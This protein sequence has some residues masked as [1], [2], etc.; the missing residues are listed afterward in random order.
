MLLTILFFADYTMGRLSDSV[1]STVARQLEGLTVI[2]KLQAEAVSIRL[3]EVQLSKF[4]DV[5]A[6]S[7][8]VDELSQAVDEFDGLLEDFAANCIDLGDK[9]LRRLYKSWQM[10]SKEVKKTTRLANESYLAE[11]EKHSMFASW[12]R[13][14]DFSNRLQQRSV[15]IEKN[16]SNKLRA[17]NE[18][19][20]SMRIKFLILSGLATLVSLLFAWFLSRSMSRRIQILH[21][22][23]L[24][25]ADGQLTNPVPTMGKDEIADLASAFNVMRLKILKREKE[26]MEA[27]SQLERR[28]RQRTMDLQ[29]ANQ[30]LEQANR[31]A[32][33]MTAE[34][35]SASKAK[36]AFLANM[37]HEI[38]TPMN[39]V[40]GMTALLLDTPLNDEQRDFA[41]A[42][43]ASGESLLNIINDILDFSKIE[44]GKL[45][46]ESI[47]FDL[48]TIFDDMADML[49]LDA[50]KKG[51]ELC[52]FIDP[53][54]P[55][56]LEGDPVRMRQVLLNL[57]N[58]AIKFTSSG[59]V[60]ILAD[61][62]TDT[63]DRVEILFQIN[64]TGIGIPENRI[65]C[66]FKSFSQA[67]GST[68][69]KYG[70][71]GLGLAI[72][73]RLV[74]LMDGQIGV[75]NKPGSGCTFWFTAWLCKQLDAEPAKLPL[76]DLHAKRILT[77][78]AHTTRRNIIHACLRSWGCESIVTANG[79]AALDLL[80]R[81]IEHKAPFEMTI[82]DVMTPEM[83]GEALGRTI[84]SDPLLKDTY[85]IQL[86]SR[87]IRG[88]AAG[89]RRTGFDACLTKPIKQSQLLNV[90]CTIFAVEPAPVP[91]SLQKA[92]DMQ[93]RLRPDPNQ[94]PR[95]LLAEDNA[96]NQKVA[97]HMLDK[98]GYQARA[99]NDGKKVIECLALEPYDLILMDIQMP[100]MDGFATTRIIRESH[101]DSRRI[102][103]I[104]MTANAMKG[105]DEK[106]LSAGMDDYIAKPV[107][108]AILEE[109][110]KLWI[111]KTHPAP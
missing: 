22:G 54:V 40:L 81:G 85:C 15:L 93:H 78:D 61:V 102:P 75:Q 28:V 63:S 100:A 6:I 48:Q 77:V 45:D 14:Q 69:R 105:D 8:A 34:A 106:C 41:E 39:G 32:Q 30:A 18:Q 20:R 108:A 91:V 51:L 70:G 71:T 62:K 7:N 1:R 72:S 56:R 55:C 29:Q 95:I 60:D 12:P 57:A 52:C 21:T 65:D 13:F 11:A 68:T 42:I 79:Q 31:M 16:A 107:D 82:I 59:E 86:T 109:K 97:L 46:F 89:I 104:A 101:N 66:L 50:E 35:E 76:A 27:Q 92:M 33:A 84:K 94:R 103:I 80:Q 74:E 10:Y 19:I 87:K 26:L 25:I 73:K 44:A 53:K 9:C 99:V 23:A 88:D 64:D 96:I 83:G 110:I 111:G 49:A 67:D 2:N 37:S 90:L 36:S 47:E 58:N 24:S 3:A 43:K 98:L 4:S 5:F 17:L 38:R